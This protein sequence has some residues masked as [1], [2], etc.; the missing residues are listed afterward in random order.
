MK[1]WDQTT[2]N[3]IELWRYYRLAALPNPLGPLRIWSCEPA[4][5]KKNLR[6]Q[7]SRHSHYPAR[8]QS[9]KMTLT[10]P[11]LS[12]NHYIN[13]CDIVVEANNRS[14]LQLANRL[15]QCASPDQAW[16]GEEKKKKKKKVEEEE[17]V[18]YLPWAG[19]GE[20]EKGRDR[21]GRWETGWLF[22]FYFEKLKIVLIL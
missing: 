3:Q 7:R 18:E 4:S 1:S 15:A 5:H 17:E 9:S 2:S 6:P 21:E 13:V 19:K 22:K 12:T 16:H 20:R 11:S 8:I 14:G 10:L